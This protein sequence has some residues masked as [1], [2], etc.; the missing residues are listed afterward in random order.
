VLWESNTICRYLAGKHNRPDLLPAEPRARE[1]VER[2]MDWQA[3]EL[4]F[5]NRYAFNALVRK[6]PGYDDAAQ[7]ES[8]VRSWN[9]QMGILDRHLAA[10]GAHAAGAEFTLADIGLG[11]AVHRWLKTPMQRA[12]YPAVTAYYERLL[13]R[14]TF[15]P[16]ALNDVP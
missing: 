3:T 11:L 14:P 16:H 8:S 7:V 6:T 4:N 15:P 5:A 2:W 10:S 9:K 13:A 1:L 12:E